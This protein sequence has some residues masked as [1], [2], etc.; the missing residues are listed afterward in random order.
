LGGKSLNVTPWE[1][2]H[3]ARNTNRTRPHRA[4]SA[5]LWGAPT[6]KGTRISVSHIALLWKAGD[7]VEEIVRSYPHLK[8]AQ[9]YDAISYYLDHQEEIE[10]E[11]QSNRM[12]Q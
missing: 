8:P 7:A 4:T 10:Q 12:A 5:D 9:V 3:D 6:I 11:I 2:K 1:R